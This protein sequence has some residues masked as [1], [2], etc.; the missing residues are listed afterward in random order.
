VRRSLLILA[1]ACAA[2]RVAPSP[3]PEVPPARPD[4]GAVTPDP[5][6]LQLDSLVYLPAPGNGVFQLFHE[7]PSLALVIEVEP[8]DPAREAVALQLVEDNGRTVLSDE[9]AAQLGLERPSR[10]WM[11]GEDG[12]CQP[13]LGSAY[14]IAEREVSLV[15]ELGY[16]VEPCAAT[17]APVAQLGPNPAA[18]RWR[19]VECSPAVQIDPAT[20]EHPQRAAYQQL[21]L[22][23]WQ[24][25]EEQQHAP[26]QWWVRSC[27]VEP[28]IVEL[29]WSWVWPEKPC[30]DGEQNSREIGWLRDGT[31]EWLPWLDRGLAAELLGVLMANE[32]PVAVFA[33]GWP[34][35]HIGTQSGDGF[36]WTALSVGDFHDEVVAAHDPWSVLDCDDDP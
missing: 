32:E 22:F 34:E 4:A 12:P 29:A 5:V 6:I 17:F 21:G 8:A 1:L 2:C 35:L 7:Q 13:T 31:V 27:A 28:M 25:G 23:D 16:L 19:D 3:V 15:L 33:S 14:A 24:P 30:W 36:V 10:V 20:W 11:F 18:L 9:Q 26:E